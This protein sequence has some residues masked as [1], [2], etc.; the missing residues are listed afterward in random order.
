M[1]FFRRKNRQLRL[2]SVYNNCY[3]D[4]VQ[5]GMNPSNKTG[6]SL[7]YKSGTVCD[8]EFSTLREIQI[9]DRNNK[10]VDRMV[11]DVV[12]TYTEPDGSFRRK[13]VI[14]DPKFLQDEKGNNFYATEMY[15]RNLASQNREFVER[16]FEEKEINSIENGYAGYI[17]VYARPEEDIRKYDGELKHHYDE[18]LQEKKRTII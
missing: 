15:Y 5:P 14:L 10:K 12:L 3:N 18:I 9:I 16:F 6:L 13:S 1:N 17:N 8:I 4:N 2:N 7:E 11:Q